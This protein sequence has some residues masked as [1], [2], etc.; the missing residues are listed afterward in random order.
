MKYRDKLK[1]YAEA[2]DPSRTLAI[3]LVPNYKTYPTLHYQRLDYLLNRYV[4]RIMQKR[5]GKRHWKKGLTPIRYQLVPEMFKN[6]HPHHHGFFE[7]PQ[8]MIDKYG[9]DGSALVLK[10][11]WEDLVPGGSAEL[12]P[13]FDPVG[14]AQYVSKENPLW[15]DYTFW[16]FRT[17]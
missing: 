5:G 1:A 6:G 7:V 10:T 13:I 15:G 4:N 8:D 14:W 16:S 9:L 2:T 17:S 11:I 3:S 12:S